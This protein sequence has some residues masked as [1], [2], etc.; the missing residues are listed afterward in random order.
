MLLDDRQAD[1][2]SWLRDLLQ[3]DADG[4]RRVISHALSPAHRR[5][6]WPPLYLA[7]GLAVALL[8]AVAMLW[9]PAPT[10]EPAWHISGSGSVIVVTSGD[11]RR[12][13][14]DRRRESHASG[15]YVITVS[16]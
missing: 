11:G 3:P 6:S 10:R 16:Q 15:E 13:V 12:W 4:V 7:F 14:L 5:R 9:R 1:P 2:E 8:V